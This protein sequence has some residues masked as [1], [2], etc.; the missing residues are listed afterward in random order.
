MWKTNIFESLEFTMGNDDAYI[1]LK[2]RFLPFSRS[3]WL[4]I[5]KCFFYIFLKEMRAAKKK[6]ALPGIFRLFRRTDPPR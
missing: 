6:A 3:P 2:R 5:W 4:G 1:L